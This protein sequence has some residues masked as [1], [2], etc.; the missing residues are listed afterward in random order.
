MYDDLTHEQAVE[1]VLNYKMRGLEIP[2]RLRSIVGEEDMEII[3]GLY[4]GLEE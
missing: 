1:L 3:E 2:A 4:D